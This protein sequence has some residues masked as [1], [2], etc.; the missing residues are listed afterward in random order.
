LAQVVLITPP[1]TQL[2]TPYPAT[3]YLKGFFNT[4]GI[5][6]F[7]ADLG[8]EVTLAI[9]SK[10]GLSK[11]F[12]EA[13]AVDSSANAKL[14]Y[15]NRQAYIS[16]VDTVISFLQGRDNTMAYRIASANYL[17]QA[18]RFEALKQQDMVHAFGV[19]GVV[20]KAKYVATMFL[21]DISDYIK[22][23]VDEHFGLTR[24]AERLGRSANTFDELYEAL[25]KPYTI[26]DDFLLSSL[27]EILQHELP[28][29]LCLSVPFPG[30]LFAA[31]RMAQFAKQNFPSVKI[32]LGGGFANTELRSVSDDR[33]FDYLDFITLDDGEAPLLQ[34]ISYI[35]NGAGVGELKRTFLFHNSSV[36]YINN[37]SC[38]DFAQAD[39]GTPTYVDLPL[40]KYISAIEIVNPMHSLWS[41]GR[42][43]KLTMA[44]GCYWGKCTFCDISLDYIKRYEPASAKLIVDRMQALVAETGHTG[45][46]FVDEAAPPSLMKAVAL[47]ILQRNIQ[48]SWWTNV[49]FEKSFTADLCL[50]LRKSGCIGVSGGLEV[51]SDRLLAMIDKGVTVE[52]VATVNKHFTNAGIMV[53]AYL[54]YG[55]PTQSAQETIDALEMVRQMFEQGVMQS[56]FWHRF[57]MTAHSP[58]GLDPAKF[59]VEAH[60][61]D[62]ISFANNDVVHD[63]LSGTDHDLFAEGLRVSLFNYM[64]GVGLDWPLQKWF[65]HKVPNTKVKP[66]YIADV[67]ANATVSS[68]KPHQQILFLG[69]MP[70][71]SITTKVKK[72]RTFEQGV[73]SFYTA[74]GIVD[75]KTDANIAQ[76][77]M[78][79]L[80]AMQVQQA[81][82][83]T[84][85]LLQQSFEELFPE[86][87]FEL[88]WFNKVQAVAGT[89]GL[90]CI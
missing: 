22:E 6:S 90:V 79:R 87:D 46:H 57:A 37:D 85:Q 9:Y 19:M 49:R 44:H 71:L 18:Q 55:F 73:L 53:H 30:N 12:G 75:L 36:T 50:L 68:P 61:A 21:E 74:N 34:V 42:W 83:C 76:W 69:N 23:C 72:G 11:V 84:Y 86:E 29:L 28:Q 67:L 65:S 62:I 52:Q 45:F 31:F 80:N 27:S 59:K 24:Y 70:S 7:Q 8:I 13:P 40:D 48:V 32:A 51:A 5:T 1:F 64:N 88:W 66:S 41:N 2:N 20:D 63:D 81:D 16:T 26:V 43:N 39:I 89:I 58:V 4:Q 78:N 56:A 15:A 77:L 38:I 10:E 35:N 14:I 54:M 47:E 82:K 3:A 25:Q 17:P 33:V 60:V